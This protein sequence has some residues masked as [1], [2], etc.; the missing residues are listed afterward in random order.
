MKDKYIV[1]SA[2]HL[3]DKTTTKNVMW[4]VVIALSPALVFA[5]YYWGFRALL[6][7]LL[8]AVS[9]V[10][11]EA[12]IQKLRRVPVTVSDG[13]A[14]L[15]GMLLS[16]NINAGAP[17]WMPIMGSVFAIAVG[18]QVFGGLGNNPVN[19]ALLGRAFLLASWPSL[20]TSGWL[21]PK[22]GALSGIADPDAIAMN[23]KALSPKA[24]DLVTGATPLKV[25]QTLRD[26]SFVASINADAGEGID[27]ANRIF[28]N[29]TEMDALKNLFWGNI[30]GCIGEVSAFALLLGAAYLLYKN[31]IEWRIPLFYIGTVF[32]LSFIFGPI[33]GAGF[34]PMLPFFHI[35]AGGLMLGAF[36]MATD[37]TTSPLTKNGRIIFAIGCGLL[38][39][40]IRFV[41]G[42]PEGVSYSIL[43]M[44]V[45]TPLIDKL[46]MPKAFGRVKK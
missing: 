12:L 2:P 43:F 38:T 16:Y 1:S 45:M 9:A 41:G 36:F 3:H 37:Y 30:G 29:I 32:V 14:F 31:I 42:Y 20:M 10:V 44:N 33:K 19:P 26:S 25:V 7:T 17:W 24:F 27:L 28:T 21:K 15:T 39:V 11:T 6:L 18:K 5:V 23:L 4:N 13:S 40:V 8:G 34:S 35:F 22:S 46:T